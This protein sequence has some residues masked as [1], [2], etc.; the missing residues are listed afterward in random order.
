MDHIAVEISL[1]DPTVQV[2]T[3]FSWNLMIFRKLSHRYQSV[4]D[5]QTNEQTQTD[6]PKLISPVQVKAGD[7]KIL[8]PKALSHSAVF[9]M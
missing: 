6:I 3:R 8:C 5:R 7:K 4:T 9:V 2:Y 1:N